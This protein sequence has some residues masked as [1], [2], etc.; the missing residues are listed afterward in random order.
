MLSGYIRFIDIILG[1]I[2]IYGAYKG[3]K[4]GFLLEVI[5]TIV[6]CVGVLL[7]FFGIAMVSSSTQEL[8]GIETPKSAVFFSYLTFFAVGAIALNLLGRKLQKMIDYSIL[9]DLD[10]IAA[11]AV[12]GTKYAFFLAI[13][14]G[15]FNTAELV[16]SEITNDSIIYPVLLEFHASIVEAGTHLA[17]TLGDRAEE[18]RELFQQD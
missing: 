9:D 11:L 18:I 10:N 2:I 4:R 15:L 8:M 13:A 17:P 12:G 3:F 16:P 5:S 14:I 6:F 1:A 7:V